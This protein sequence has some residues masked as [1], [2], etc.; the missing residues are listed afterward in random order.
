MTNNF[1]NSMIAQPSSAAHH[2]LS[3]E[4]QIAKAKIDPSFFR[5]MNMPARPETSTSKHNSKVVISTSKAH[6]L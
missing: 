2:N 1:V 3:I 4:A 5:P 6:A